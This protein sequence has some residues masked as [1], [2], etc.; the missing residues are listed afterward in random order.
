MVGHNM[1]LDLMFIY[2][3]FYEPLPGELFKMIDY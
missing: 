1:L 3:K 2:D